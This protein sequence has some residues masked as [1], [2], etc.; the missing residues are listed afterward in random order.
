MLAADEAREPAPCSSAAVRRGPARMPVAA[1]AAQ[2]LETPRSAQDRAPAGAGRATGRPRAHPDSV[3]FGTA[4]ASGAV[5][6]AR[7]SGVARRAAPGREGLRHAFRARGAPRIGAHAPGARAPSADGSPSVRTRAAGTGRTTLPATARGPA[8]PSR[9]TLLARDRVPLRRAG[10]TAPRRRRR[11]RRR[12]GSPPRLAGLRTATQ[13]SV[14]A[15]AAGEAATRGHEAIAWR[16]PALVPPTRHRRSRR[17]R[18]SVRGERAD[19]R[20]PRAPWRP[21]I[22]LASAATTSSEPRTRNFTHPCY[23]PHAR[24]GPWSQR[25][26]GG[27]TPRVRSLTDAPAMA[28][29]GVAWGEASRCARQGSVN[30]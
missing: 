20:V 12:A 15:R 10:R 7:A 24:L 25:C 9:V 14:R 1:S 30:G 5:R 18:P 11:S 29:Y 28:P 26:H 27:D 22:R 21:A 4:P 13:R 19:R 2:A 3:R 17:P 6:R 23:A 8:P 16:R